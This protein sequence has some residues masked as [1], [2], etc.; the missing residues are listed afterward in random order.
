MSK[1]YFQDKVISLNNTFFC[2]GK[3]NETIFII[4]SSFTEI[5]SIFCR[6]NRS[7]FRFFYK[8]TFGNDIGKGVITNVITFLIFLGGYLIFDLISYSR[9]EGPPYSLFSN[10]EY[11][12]IENYSEFVLTVSFSGESSY[13]CTQEVN[14]SGDTP[15]I[16]SSHTCIDN[17]CESKYLADGENLGL[18]SPLRLSYAA[19]IIKPYDVVHLFDIG[20][21]YSLRDSITTEYGSIEL[22]IQYRRP[23]IYEWLS[24]KKDSSVRETIYWYV[25]NDNVPKVF[26]EKSLYDYYFAEDLYSQNC[27]L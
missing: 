12:M 20:K 1:R 6:L 23:L 24:L 17:S 11:V 7:F 27:F 22:V 3:F 14:D 9:L 5:S 15:S 26:S 2:K 13:G 25:C 4:K 10:G 19:N 16:I 8:A 21:N 18:Y